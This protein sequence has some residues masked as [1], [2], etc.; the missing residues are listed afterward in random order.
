MKIVVQRV[1][2]ASVTVDGTVTGSINQGLLLLIGIHESD[3][4]KEIDW[5]SKKISK[6]RIFEDDDG[7][8]N[9]SV[10]DVEGGILAV[11][12]FT[13]YGNTRKGTRPSF[14]EAAKPDV[15][16]PLYDYMVERFKKITNLNV[17]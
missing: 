3:S 16:E 9:R 6:L 13:L 10:Q 11:S 4:K 1:K 15:A 7:K 12:Q 14:I 17:Q 8:M 5:C 2:R